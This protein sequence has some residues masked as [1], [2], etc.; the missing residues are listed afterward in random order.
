[1]HLPFVACI[2]YNAGFF[3]GPALGQTLPEFPDF[4]QK[5][6][7]GDP[8]SNDF[9]HNHDGVRGEVPASPIVINEPRNS[10]VVE[11]SNDETRVLMYQ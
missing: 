9:K 4:F 8:T 6:E 11:S 7:L 1:M 5:R 2:L 10:E 3:P